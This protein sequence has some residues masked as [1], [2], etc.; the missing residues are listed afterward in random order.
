MWFKTENR[1]EVTS[2]PSRV[3]D[4]DSCCSSTRTKTDPRP[5][6]SNTWKQ[7]PRHAIKAA[8][9]D[10][11]QLNN[12]FYGL[13]WNRLSAERRRAEGGELLLS[14][15]TVRPFSL[16]AGLERTEREGFN[17]R[18]KM[19]RALPAVVT[20]FS[21][22]F[23]LTNIAALLALIVLKTIITR[24]SEFILDAFRIPTVTC[25]VILW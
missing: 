3:H 12:S 6:G 8:S 15:K 1:E 21:V 20:V 13:T 25:R 14:S 23:A 18:H 16:A 24:N 7:A 22:G 10:H 19:C 11:I 4:G 2:S 9:G 5:P 17:A